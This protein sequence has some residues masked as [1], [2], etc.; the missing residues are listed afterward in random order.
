MKH[1]THA[2]GG[3]SDRKKER[4]RKNKT[5]NFAQKH[6]HK[7]SY[8]PRLLQLS[9]TAGHFVSFLYLQTPAGAGATTKVAR[10][11]TTWCGRV[12]RPSP[13]L[14][15]CGGPPTPPQRFHRHR[16]PAVTYLHACFLSVT[17]RCPAKELNPRND[18]G[19]VEC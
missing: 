15:P 10:G 14:F 11:A 12:S 13:C 7:R 16:E 18:G 5:R 19:G 1:T 3:G 17:L 4:K 6:Q 2:A 8:T 9:K